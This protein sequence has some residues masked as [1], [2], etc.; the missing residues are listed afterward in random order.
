MQNKPAG[1]QERFGLTTCAAAEIG[2]A[3]LATAPGVAVIYAPGEA[4]EKIY[5]ILE[6]RAGALRS[7]CERRLQ[8]GKLPP[9]AELCVAFRSG[10]QADQS[11]EAVNAACRE[12]VIFAGELRRE[13]RPAM[14]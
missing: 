13:L 14:R 12:Q 7:Q 2:E 8:S 4:G 11:P 9:T 1:W 10:L 6:S 5:L 3:M